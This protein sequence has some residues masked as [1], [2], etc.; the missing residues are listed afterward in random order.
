MAKRK[1]KRA[2][3][4]PTGLQIKRNDT[5]Y[6][7]SWNHGSAT[8]AQRLQY[9]FDNG[10]KKWISVSVTKSAR[11]IERTRAMGNRF[12]YVRFR[13]K[14]R[15]KGYRWSNWSETKMSIIYPP[16]PDKPKFTLN[17]EVGGKGVFATSLKIS[18]TDRRPF[19]KVKWQTCV[20]ETGTPAAYSAEQK[21]STGYSDTGS[22]SVSETVTETP[23]DLAKESITRYFRAQSLGPGG[24]SA[25]AETYHVYALPAACD[26]IENECK[27]VDN[28]AG[29]SISVQYDSD[30]L[31]THHPI[32]GATLQCGMVTPAAGLS[33]PAD[34]SMEDTDATVA[35]VT[36]PGGMV[37][38]TSSKLAL[39]QCLF[40]AVKTTHDH[41]SIT[42]TPLLLLKGRL[43]APTIDSVEVDTATAKA[44]VK[45]TNNSEVPDAQMVVYYWPDTDESHRTIV[46]TCKSDVSA[47]IDLES[48]ADAYRIGV[49]AIQGTV[50]EMQATNPGEPRFVVDSNMESEIT[51]ENGALPR[52]PTNVRAAAIGSQSVTVEWDWN[53]DQAVA[54]VVSWSQDID[55]WRSNEDPS[56]VTVPRRSAPSWNIVNLGTGVTW[57]F[58]VRFLTGEGDDATGGDWSD[59]TDATTVDLS[60]APTTPHLTLS[61]DVILAG[62]PITAAWAYATGD[63][64]GQSYAEIWEADVGSTGITPTKMVAQTTSEQTIIIDTKTAG[65]ESGSTHY[66]TLRLTSQSGRQ[67]G[68]A[69][70]VKVV[71]A[72]A[73][74][75]TIIQS[76]LVDVAEDDLT[77]HQLQALP[78]TVTVTGAGIGGTTSVAITRQYDYHLTRPDESR[79]DGYAG[80]TIA[81]TSQTG[82]DQITITYDDLIGRL[83]D[84]ARYEIAATVKDVR[85]QSD[86]VRLPFTVAWA[87]QPFIPSATI[88]VDDDRL[89]VKITPTVPGG[90]T[91][92][93]GDVCDIYR[94]SADH[95]VLIYEGAEFGETYVDPYPAFGEGCGHRV[96]C[97]T[98]NGDYMVDG[99]FAWYDATDEEGDYIDETAVTVD[100]DAG[101]VQIP[102]DVQLENQW[103]KSFERTAYLGGHVAGDWDADVSRSL[104]VSA[105]L[106]MDEDTDELASLRDLADYPGICH[107][108]TPDG[109]SFAANVDVEEKR[110]VRKQSVDVSLTI[111]QV[112]SEGLDGMTLAE[113]NEEIE[114]EATA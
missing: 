45:A 21:V 54:A 25:W 9:S 6:K 75:A 107:V 74:K 106:I 55:S 49:Q 67:S 101:Q 96:V 73:V 58:R 4:R 48:V 100:F 35:S 10:K 20:A 80:E 19:E 95:P 43:K 108:R 111:T 76:S 98:G 27:A 12:K 104:S 92:A 33:W 61:K 22:G 97:R 51:W 72:D 94:L 38:N 23:A 1:R 15:N 5:K 103:E 89:A 11:S 71:V 56:T 91:A 112:D 87:H 28:G 86:T 52:V 79:Y 42:G 44:T 46:G 30:Q 88:E 47:T 13:V 40:A 77:I 2:S 59:I 84:S 66:L 26:L 85:G 114:E 34:G 53:D 32:D 62:D 57:Y 24:A 93:D 37:A 70:A 102:W 36:L 16:A 63:G 109:S 60:S 68:W 3:G 110:E 78:I 41:Q 83:D 105:D 14:K 8:S 65:W 17:E 113:W 50:T 69:P 82:E 90:V 39:D 64:T 18:K 99:Y 7:F 31:L 29:Y 81:V